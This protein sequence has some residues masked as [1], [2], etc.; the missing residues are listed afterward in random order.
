MYKLKDPNT[1]GI[2]NNA[3]ISQIIGVTRQYLSE[4]KRGKPCS[5]LV[6]YCITKFIDNNKEIEDFFER[7]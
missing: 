4:I 1:L 6:A 7:V 5:K 2:Y 3:K